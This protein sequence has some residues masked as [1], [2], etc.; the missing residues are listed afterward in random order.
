MKQIL[1]FGAIL[2]EMIYYKL[3]HLFVLSNIHSITHLLMKQ[4][5]IIEMIY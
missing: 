2:N 3:S 5:V 1:Y 4:K